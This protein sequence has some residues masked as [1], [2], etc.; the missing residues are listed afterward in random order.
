[1]SLDIQSK[2]TGDQ[3][4][5]LQ[6]TGSLDQ[7]TYQNFEKTVNNLIKENIKQLMIDMQHVDYLSSAGIGA[8]VA[9]KNII[10]KKSANFSIINLQ[11][12]VKKVIEVM[13]LSQLLNVS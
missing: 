12:K 7:E 10:E 11:P 6:L 8:L 1:M 4:Y 13:R 5:C 9:A 2:I 3:V